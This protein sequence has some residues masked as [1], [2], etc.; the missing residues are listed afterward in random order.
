MAAKRVVKWKDM[1]K[2]LKKRFGKSVRTLARFCHR[3]KELDDFEVVLPRGKLEEDIVL[4]VGPLVA[5]EYKVGREAGDGKEKGVYRHAA[6]DLGRGRRRA[7]LML[8]VDRK[9]LPVLYRRKGSRPGFSGRG[10]TG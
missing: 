10:L 7:P 8:G 4:Q 3:E 5:L 2:A 6:G 9:G 1:P